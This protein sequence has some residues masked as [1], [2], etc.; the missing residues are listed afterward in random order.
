M[1][2][3]SPRLPE[4]KPKPKNVELINKYSNQAREKQTKLFSDA[5]FI[6]QKGQSEKGF[7]L[8]QITEFF[9]NSVQVAVI[10]RF[11]FKKVEVDE[12]ER[13][14]QLINA[15][16][17]YFFCILHNV[18]EI[19]CSVLNLQK[20]Q[21]KEFGAQLV[22]YILILKHNLEQE[23]S[24]ICAK[25]N[26]LSEEAEKIL[27]N[28]KSC[29]EELK[30]SFVNEIS[31]RCSNGLAR[32]SETLGLLEDL[33]ENIIIQEF[34]FFPECSVETGAYNELP[35]N[36]SLSR[37]YLQLA[38]SILFHYTQSKQASVDLQGDLDAHGT[39]ME[40]INNELK[41]VEMAT[42]LLAHLYSGEGLSNEKKKE[43]AGY[44]T[45]GEESF[46]KQSFQSDELTAV[47]KERAFAEIFSNSVGD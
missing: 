27:V 29:G 43:Y 14:Y 5:S 18:G 9:R 24:G 30:E 40:E 22:E 28:Q 19:G 4:P 13:M 41:R 31:E 25:E 46:S 17:L 39:S 33:K 36:Y 47:L 34:D 37:G 45:R 20:E 7:D 42:S 3:I 16:Y 1:N 32:F 21:T 8:S 44:F 2:E 35:A 38:K 12:S 26:T 6:D 15:A 11:L 23:L 10:A